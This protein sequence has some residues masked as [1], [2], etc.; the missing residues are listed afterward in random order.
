MELCDMTLIDAMTD[1]SVELSEDLAVRCLKHMLRGIDYMH[2]KKI[3]HRDLKPENVFVKGDLSTR[4]FSIKLSDFGLSEKIDPRYNGVQGKCGTRFYWPPEMLY[5]SDSMWYSEKIDEW[6][7][8]HMFFQLVTGR[9]PFVKSVRASVEANQRKGFDGISWERKRGKLNLKTLFSEDS[10]KM[11]QRL[12]EQEPEDRISAENALL[13]SIFSLSQTKTRK[14][15]E[16]SDDIRQEL[17]Q[18]RVRQKLTKLVNYT[19]MASGWKKITDTVCKLKEEHVNIDKLVDSKTIRRR[20]NEEHLKSVPVKNIVEKP[21]VFKAAKTLRNLKIEDKII[22]LIVGE[23][24]ARKSEYVTKIRNSKFE[25]LEKQLNIKFKIS[26]YRPNATFENCLTN[27]RKAGN[28]VGIFFDLS[29]YK[30]QFTLKEEIRKFKNFVQIA[31]QKFPDCK[32]LTSCIDSNLVYADRLQ[33]TRIFMQAGINIEFCEP[34]YLHK[35]DRKYPYAKL[36]KMVNF[37]MKFLTEQ[38]SLRQTH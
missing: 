14:R 7:I 9:N 18:L 37:A 26:S 6:A 29:S 34:R 12:L 17:F 5:G 28:I 10:Y 31:E 30:I 33:K 11:L 19:I 8:G 2:S 38:Y 16:M 24:D 20:F 27:T 32:I 1:N 23:D 21:D 3:V 25:G 15:N 22:V 36:Q 13:D 35:P 4:N